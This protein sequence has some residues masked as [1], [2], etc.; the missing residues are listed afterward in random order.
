MVTRQLNAAQPAAAT[1]S[2]SGSIHSSASSRPCQ[3]PGGY[4]WHGEAGQAPACGLFHPAAQ[5]V[6]S[7]PGVV[8]DQPGQIHRVINAGVVE[9]ECQ[10]I[11]L[12]DA[13]P[14]F[15]QILDLHTVKRFFH[16]MVKEHLFV[17]L[18]A[19]RLD[20]FEDL[21]DSHKGRGSQIMRERKSQTALPMKAGN[22]ECARPFWPTISAFPKFSPR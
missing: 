10:L 13:L 18:F 9:L 20:F 14:D 17:A 15:L 16:A 5:V 6:V 7:H 11:I 1:W 22:L 3:A 12:P 2:V 21:L 4:C 8:S 19:Q